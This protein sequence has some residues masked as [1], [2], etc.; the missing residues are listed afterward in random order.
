MLTFDLFMAGQVGD[1]PRQLENPRVAARGKTETAGDLLEQQLTGTVQSAEETDV[2][3]LHL[4]VG[5]QA[6]TGQATPLNLAG[7]VDPRAN[8]GAAL[9]RDG[10][11]QILVWHPW[12]LDV[13][14]DPVQQRAG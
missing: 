9:Q 2:A 1:G 14:I 10:C 12:H 8:F 5:M 6:E 3:T 13:Q 7:L 11:R 4:G